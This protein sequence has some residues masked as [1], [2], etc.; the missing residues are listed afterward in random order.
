MHNFSLFFIRRPIA[1]SLIV[2]M[3][4]VFGILAYFKLPVSDL[5]SV[6]YPVMVVSAFYPGA[7]PE[8]MA[9]TVANPL[10]QQLMKISGIKKV[11]SQNTDSFTK[12]ILTFDTDKNIDL[13]TPDVQAAI[14]RAKGYLPKLPDDPSFSK[15]NPSDKP[16]MYITVSSDSLSH[17]ELFD[18]ANKRISQPLSML[19]GISNVTIWSVS[20]AVRIKVDPSKMA[21]YKLTLADVSNAIYSNTMHASGGSLNGD[22]R[23]FSIEPDAQLITPDEYN[24]LIVKYYNSKPVRISDIGSAYLSPQQENYRLRCFN[25]KDKK[26]TDPILMAVTKKPEANIIELTNNIKKEISRLRTELPSDVNISFI[27][28]KSDRVVKS[29]KDV[30]QTLLI[31][32]IL[33]VLVIFMFMGRLVD[34]IIPTIILPVS[35]ITTFIVIYLCGFSIDTLSLLAVTLAIGFIVDDSI[36]VLENTIRHLEKGEK[37]FTSVIMSIKEISGSVI[38]MTI[39]LAIVFV[40]VILLGGIVG[41]TFREFAVTV[42]IIVICSGIF[43]LTLTPMMNSGLLKPISRKRFSWLQKKRNKILDKLI[44]AYSRLLILFLKRP[45]LSLILWAVCIT[46]AFL[47]YFAV[48]KTFM[49]PGD[50]GAIFGSIK[51]PVGT[52]DKPIEKYQDKINEVLKDNPNIKDF[53]TITGIY[54]GADKSMGSLAIMLKPENQR[55]PMRKVVSEIRQQLSKIPYNIGEIYLAPVP[56]LE[57]NTQGTTTASGAQYSYMVTSTSGK[58]VFNFAEKLKNGMRKSQEFVDVQSDVKLDLP[59]IDMKIMRNKALS[60]GISI[61]DIQSTLLYAY[62]LGRVTQFTVGPNPYDVILQVEDKFRKNPE[63]L[64]H[65]YVRSSLNGKLI[66]LDTI[67]TWKKVAAPA[68]ITHYQQLDAATISFNLAS[69]VSLGSATDKIES[70]SKKLFPSSVT[71]RFQ[72]E[73]AQFISLKES[74]VFSIVIAVFLLYI[75]LGILYESYIHPFTVLT[76]LP[77]A[78]I[79]GLGTLILFN[80]QLSLYAY[81]GLFLLLGI[82]VKNGIMIVDFAIRRITYNKKSSF[83]AIHD[84][85]IA[86]F[87]PILMT[88]LTSIFGA[89]PIAL[90]IGID[91]SIRQPLGLVIVGGL[92]LSQ[93]LTLFVT[94]GIFIYM[95]Y[96]QEKYLDKFRLTRTRRRKNESK[97]CS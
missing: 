56:V 59:Q 94:P 27:Y 7:S 35:I 11:I 17:G 82:V 61:A 51:V 21:D 67:T 74:F 13:M 91:G 43:S 64:S 78:V 77:V 34:T 3:L 29:I 84:A 47:L 66:P 6:G 30:K 70:L 60:L 48:H 73:A 18:I 58:N 12:I 87:R 88:G 36:V 57:L 53:F 93:L 65:L 33:V 32:F 44:T 4:I 31:T 24:N 26:F 8:T 41:R 72:G 40:P 19:T 20:S 80:S 92:V 22:N 9:E 54:A 71:G 52:A 62:S 96:I 45:Y 46:G 86:R 38:S 16:I 81:V 90:G 2:L 10:E 97:I 79:G 23:T 14:N 49:P 89:V 1:T 63:D 55:E 39:S 25:S 85:C 15:Y 83:D 28:D 95:Q 69:G 76:T 5:P 37:V 42:M 68:M 50:S 75:L